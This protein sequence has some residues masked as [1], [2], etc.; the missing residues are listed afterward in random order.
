MRIIVT[1]ACY[2]VHK[3]FGKQLPVP[4]ALALKEEFR[5]VL[6]LLGFTEQSKQAFFLFM[7]VV[8]ALYVFRVVLI[9]RCSIEK[10][11]A[12]YLHR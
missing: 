8:S 5:S 10:A 4:V 12:V 11:A 3:P 1:V 2:E 7:A 9:Y 6:L